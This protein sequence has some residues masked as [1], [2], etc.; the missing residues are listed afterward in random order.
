MLTKGVLPPAVLDTVANASPVTYEY[1]GAGYFLTLRHA[2]LP[3]ERI[4]CDK[5]RVVGRSEGLETGF[6]VFLENH[7]LTLE[8]HAWSQ[9]SVPETYRDQDVAIVAT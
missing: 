5:P 9:N 1:T 8:C 6:I 7:E 3:K 2:S 4:V